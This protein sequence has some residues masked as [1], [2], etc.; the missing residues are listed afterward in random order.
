MV[1]LL[2]FG[3]LAFGIKGHYLPLNMKID[4]HRDMQKF[5][6]SGIDS[7]L[8]NSKGKKRFTLLPWA[9]DYP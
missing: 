5:T 4:T 9:F 3:S 7:V 8:Q 2:R 1:K 6:K